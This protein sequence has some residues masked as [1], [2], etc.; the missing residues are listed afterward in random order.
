MIL[1][2]CSY[3]Q[4]KPNSVSV[5]GG[6]SIAT[7]QEHFVAEE[8]HGVRDL[9]KGSCLMKAVVRRVCFRRRYEFS[10]LLTI[11]LNL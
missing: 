9:R 8:R 1:T 3:V 4:S 10:D 6:L 2:R 5:S 7:I 11:Y